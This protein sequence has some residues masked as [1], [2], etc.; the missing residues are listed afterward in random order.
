M[1]DFFTLLR[2]EQVGKAVVAVVGHMRLLKIALGYGLSPEWAGPGWGCA[3][4]RAPR[5]FLFFLP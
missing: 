1:P 3:G 4:G 2:L 5:W